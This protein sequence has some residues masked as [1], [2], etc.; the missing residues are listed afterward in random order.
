MEGAVLRVRYGRGFIVGRRNHLSYIDRIV[1]T[2]AHC[3][4]KK[5]PP[6]HPARYADE[7]T[8]R[9]LLGPLGGKCTVWAE[10][11]FVDP[12]ADIAMLGQPD[13]QTFGDQADAYDRLVENMDI[14]GVADAPAHSSER[15]TF[16][17]YHIDKP[18]PGE[19]PARV[20][21]LDG[22]WHNGRV[23]RF[24]VL[25]FEPED[26]IVS[27]MSGSPILNAEGAAIG[28]VSVSSMSPV[29]VD[30]LSARLVRDILA[31]NGAPVEAGPR[32]Q[33]MSCSQLAV[34]GARRKAK[35]GDYDELTRMLA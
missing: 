28:V 27:G 6:C 9:N 25:T 35:N 23:R 32:E 1:I 29:I 33:T 24:G 12:I 14:L 10:C 20:L 2:A 21:S 19:G 8:Y 26:L 11:L 30:S 4:P 17:D 22:R 34:M 7:G 18:I 13:N 31:A 3:L 15:V 16:K 5:L